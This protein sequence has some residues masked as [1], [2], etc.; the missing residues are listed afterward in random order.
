MALD[1]SALYGWPT[2]SEIETAAGNIATYGAGVGTAVADAASEW[3]LLQRHYDAP[4]SQEALAVFRNITP[5]GEAIQTA[6]ED[7]RNALN[8]FAAGVESLE[9]TRKTLLAEIE[10]FR[11][12]PPR[13]DPSDPD[14]EVLPFAEM[15]LDFR[16]HDLVLQYQAFET[17]CVTA[18]TGINGGPK[19]GMGALAGPNFGLLPGAVGNHT[20][21]YTFEKVQIADYREVP[22]PWQEY[23]FTPIDPEALTNAERAGNRFLVVDGREISIHD[24]EHPD[25]GRTRQ[26]GFFREG[27]N[28]RIDWRPEVNQ[29]M[30][31]LLPKYSQRVDDNPYKWRLEPDE[32]GNPRRPEAPPFRDLPDGVKAAKAGGWALSVAMAGVTFAD[33]RAKTYNDLLKEDPTMSESDREFRANEVGTVRTVAKTGVDLGAGLAGAAVGTAIGGPIGTV[34]GFGVGLGVSY[35]SDVELPDWLGGKSVKDHAADLAVGGYDAVSGAIADGWNAVF[36]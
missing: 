11:N 25:F 19:Q 16:I 29:R 10:A 12:N 30:Y 26:E 24:P 33:E 17:E 35:L 23:R 9:G 8:A 15:Q 18:L 7:A 3:A 31:D 36:G 34:V 1:T 20:G 13:L 5:H 21:L 27:F 6:A 14:S 4:E 22:V 32:S 2:P 28:T